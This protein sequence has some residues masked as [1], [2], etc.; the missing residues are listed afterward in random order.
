MGFEP[1]RAEHIGLAV[2][3]LNHSATSSEMVNGLTVPIFVHLLI[4]QPYILCINDSQAN[5]PEKDH[6]RGFNNRMQIT[7]CESL[8][9]KERV[10]RNYL[11]VF[12]R[13]IALIRT[14]F[15][16]Q[17]EHCNVYFKLPCICSELLCACS[18]HRKQPEWWH[19]KK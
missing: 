1:T 12:E 9:A 8:Y 3:R 15:D 14:I 5:P 17:Y 13:R 19:V 18:T 11:Q 2:Q 16:V 10:W 7:L 4:C 6:P